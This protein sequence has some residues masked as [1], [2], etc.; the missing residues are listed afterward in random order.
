VENSSRHAGTSVIQVPMA[1]SWREQMLDRLAAASPRRVWG[2]AVATIVV[3]GAAD[4]FGGAEVALSLVYL[5][6]IA[7]V[8]WSQGQ[9]AAAVAAWLAAGAWLLVDLHS[10]WD[11][12]VTALEIVN[13]L[14]LLTVFHLFGQLLATLR[15]RLDREWRHGHTDPLTGLHN[16]RAFW[17][18]CGREVER[19][20]RFGEP[21]TLAY[22][23]VDRFKGVNDRH[24]HAVGD[25]LLL[26]IAAALGEDLRQLD[27]VARLGG[28]EFALL[29]PGTHAFG[30]KKA[31]ERLR[32][33]LQS[34]DWRRRYDVDF[35]LGCLTVEWAPAEVDT[36]IQRAD[37]LMYEIKRAGSGGLRHEVLRG[38]IVERPAPPRGGRPLRS[39]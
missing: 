28:D 38:P 2:L 3:V 29:L 36:V 32:E 22:L 34:A 8:A 19:C 12:M 37:Q 24:G 27:M 15:D 30:A 17:S 26:T 7:M 13:G 35:S 4:W 18:A 21:F 9:R 39:A 25:Q 33:R 5:L 31:L 14:V 20:R 1:G 6:P 16:R 23:D 10:H 11:E